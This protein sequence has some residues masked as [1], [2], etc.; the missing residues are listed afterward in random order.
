LEGLAGAQLAV[1]NTASMQS[2]LAERYRPRE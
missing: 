2:N 1:F